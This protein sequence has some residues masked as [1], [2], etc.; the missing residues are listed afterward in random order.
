M[1]KKSLAPTR[2]KSVEEL[3][4]EIVQAR[5]EMGKEKAAVAHGS[6]AE[7]PAKIRDLRRKIATLLT[8]I[9]EKKIG[10]RSK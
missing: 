2:D 7:K 9:N 4:A 5:T 10:G 1:S 8:I 3:E 6:R